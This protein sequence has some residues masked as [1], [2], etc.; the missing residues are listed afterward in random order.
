MFRKCI[1]NSKC[2]SRRLD[3]YTA[4]YSH[5]LYPNSG[6]LRKTFKI[7]QRSKEMIN[8]MNNLVAKGTMDH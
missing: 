3:N 1:Q 6:G 8:C 5:N 2:I 4:I 7:K